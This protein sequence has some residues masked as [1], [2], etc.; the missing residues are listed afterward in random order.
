MAVAFWKL[1]PV[2]YAVIWYVVGFHKVET[3]YVTD[4]FPL[5]TLLVPILFAPNW[6]DTVKFL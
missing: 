5:L 3:L 1:V 2:T 6:N 4:A